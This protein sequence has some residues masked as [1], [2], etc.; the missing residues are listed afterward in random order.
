MPRSV[1][2]CFKPSTLRDLTTDSKL[3]Q[4]RT[5]A[6]RVSGNGVL[7]RPFAITNYITKAKG[8]RHRSKFERIKTGLWVCRLQSRT[9]A[10]KL[11]PILTLYN[12][13]E[14]FQPVF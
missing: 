11:V 8:L 12:K 4:A 14:F 9:I 7:D 6:Y 5:L 2:P 1:S 3:H 13:P 10:K